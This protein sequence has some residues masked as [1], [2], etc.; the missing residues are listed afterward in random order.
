MPVTCRRGPHRRRRRG[1]SSLTVV[2]PLQGSAGAERGSASCGQ[3]RFDFTTTTLPAWRSSI[4]CGRAGYVVTVFSKAAP[5]GNSVS[6]WMRR[7]PRPSRSAR[8]P[9]R[10]SGTVTVRRPTLR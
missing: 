10:V 2:D 1:S 9:R 8:V 5:A 6:S 7:S 4:S 3:R